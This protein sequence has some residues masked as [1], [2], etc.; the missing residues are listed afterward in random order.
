[1]VSLDIHHTSLRTNGKQ[2]ERIKNFPFM[3]SLS[4]HS[5]HFSATYEP[6]FINRAVRAVSGKQNESTDTLTVQTSLS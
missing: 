3:L 6:L 5:E 4:K 1:M 2:F